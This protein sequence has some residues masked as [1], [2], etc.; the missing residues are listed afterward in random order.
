MFI[1]QSFDLSPDTIIT[2]K[3]MKPNF[4]FN[5]FGEAVYYRTYSRLMENGKNEQWADTVIRVIEGVIE[6]RK[7]HYIKNH[8]EWDEDYW[9]QYA[10]NMAI[11]MFTMEWLP[12]GRGLWA[13]GT[14]CI[15]QRGSAFLYNCGFVN[16]K[17]IVEAA[18]WMTDMLMC[19]CGVGFDDQWNGQV[20][21]PNKKNKFTFIVPDS[22]EGWADSVK[23]LLEAYIPDKSSGKVKKFPIFDYS[24]LRSKGTPLKTFGGISSGPAPLIKLHAR[25]EIY[26]DT[27]LEY[28]EKKDSKVFLTMVKKLKKW[29]HVDDK[30]YLIMLKQLKSQLKNKTYDRCRLIADIFNAIAACVVAGGI[31]RS[32]QIYLGRSGNK[33]FLNLKNYKL[34]P[35]RATIGWSSNNSVLLK[36]TKDFHHIPSL[37]EL[38][39]TNGEPGLI[40]MINVGRYGRVGKH[41]S[42]TTYPTREHEPDKAKGFNPCGEIPEED[43]ELCNLSEVFPM[44]CL[45]NNKFDENKFYSACKY[46][47]FYSSTVS[48]LPT[49]RS[50]SNK[51]IARNR[52]IGV[53][54][55]GLAMWYTA[56]G[57]TK[58]TSIC[59]EGYKTVRLMNNKLA[60]EAGVPSSIRVTTIKPSGTISQL[61]GQT[62]GAHYPEGDYFIR[63]MR[64][65]E[66]LPFT[67]FLKESGLYW[68]KDVYSDNTLVFSFPVSLGEI[69]TVNDVSLAE[70]MLLCSFLQREWADNSV[71]FTGKFRKEEIESLEHIIAMSMPSLKGLSLMPMD[72]D[73][74][75][76]MPYERITKE[77]YKQLLNI[78]PKLEWCKFTGNDPDGEADKYCNGDICMII[79]KKKK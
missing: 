20:M 16:T 6:I 11:S 23:M 71:S 45:T 49:H 15:R 64:A 73:N 30:S 24:K 60:Q 36:E 10:H 59:R 57:I 5:G 79:K 68:E 13:M 37:V 34:N 4:G 19:G 78:H 48:L 39:K 66:G 50:G 38:I 40:N 27:Y 31:R 12:P 62:S 8:L 56:I 47:T 46:A 77:K 21:K 22:R 76:Q 1:N 18:H 33:T 72:N 9:Q 58:M 69:R 67:N 17:N 55:S 29:N 44:R 63:R 54:L 74:Y 51:V 70:S 61:A 75:Q 65:N 7:E 43:K 35:E 28:D 3:Q 14:D 26:L 53:S 41:A 52:R 42:S 2:L 32:S 25:I